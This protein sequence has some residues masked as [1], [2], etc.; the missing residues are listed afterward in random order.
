MKINLAAPVRAL[1]LLAAVTLLPACTSSSTYVSTERIRVVLGESTAAD[2]T[3]VQH[4]LVRSGKDGV[5]IHREETRAVE[6]PYIGV[7]GRSLDAET[8]ANRAVPAWRGVLVTSVTKGTAAEAAG[9]VRG[10]ILVSVGGSE[11][12]SY[13]QFVEVAGSLEPGVAVEMV[14]SSAATEGEGRSERVLDFV[15]GSRSVDE[16]E[17]TR[18]PLE[19]DPMLLERAGLEVATVPEDVVR[20]IYA[21]EGSRALVTG[22]WI[23]GPA[24]KEGVRGGDVV[25][26]CNGQSVSTAA[27]V[28]RTVNEGARRLELQVEGPLGAHEASFGLVKDVTEEVDFDIPILVEHSSRVGRSRTSVLDFIFQFGWNHRSRALPS[29]TREPRSSSYLSIL[30]FGMFEFTRRPG[31]SENRIFWIISWGSDS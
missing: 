16:T 27:D 22:V 28:A 8:A 12:T 17:V 30:P 13:E 2:G 7:K 1:A 18:V 26:S 29:P 11:L 6:L 24:Y 15:V 4:R 23:G 3:R 21:G 31:S 25:Q 5:A 9:I 19:P 10:D 20:E 14:I